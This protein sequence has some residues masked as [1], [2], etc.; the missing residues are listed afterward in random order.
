M[1]SIKKIEKIEGKKLLEFCEKIG[2]LQAFGTPRAEPIGKIYEMP[3]GRV[4]IKTTLENV[5]LGKKEN[6]LIGVG[7]QIIDLNKEQ[8]KQNTPEV[9][10]ETDKDL[11][12]EM[13]NYVGHSLKV[14]SGQPDLKEHPVAIFY[15]EKN[16]LLIK[17]LV[18]SRNK[19]YMNS[20]RIKE[21]AI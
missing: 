5:Y 3:D 14:G 13:E 4:I 18:T 10:V 17:A 16:K 8:E 7:E 19:I 9:T 15:Q 12:S 21:V 2:K 6:N 11:L 20:A 1:I